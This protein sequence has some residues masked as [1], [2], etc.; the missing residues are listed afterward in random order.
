MATE[1][2]KAEF[3]RKVDAVTDRMRDYTRPCV[4]PLVYGFPGQKPVIGTGTYV[5]LYPDKV[6]V[7]HILTC[8]HVS[9]TQPLQH[10][11]VGSQKM[12]PLYGEV[13]SDRD[14][15]DA[16]AIRIEKAAW[17]EQKHNADPLPVSLL[18]PVHRPVEN[19]VLFVR[20][21]AGENF[22]EA[23]DIPTPILS[24]YSTQEVVSQRTGRDFHIIWDPTKVKLTSKTDEGVVA[25]FKHSDPHGFSGSL[26]WNTRFVELGSDLSQWNPE[27]AVVTGMLR[28]GDEKSRLLVAQQIQHLLP[29]LP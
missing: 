10:L 9:R 24:A 19:E 12:L 29:W 26:V 21:M 22:H 17:R 28:R 23:F 11:P 6:D 1:E 20:G 13:R 18:A 5:T 16:A 4:T 7:V 3:D 14:P 2:A 25:R 8:E 15:L 27:Q